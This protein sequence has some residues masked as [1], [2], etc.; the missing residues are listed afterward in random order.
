MFGLHAQETKLQKGVGKGIRQGSDCRHLKPSCCFATCSY[1]P[2]TSPSQA[3]INY[4][5]L[6]ALFYKWKESCFHRIM[7]TLKKVRESLKTLACSSGLQKLCNISPKLFLMIASVLLFSIHQIDN[8]FI[9][10][11]E[12]I[13]YSCSWALHSLWTGSI[14]EYRAKKISE[15]SWVKKIRKA[16]CPLLADFF[17][18]LYPTT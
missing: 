8:V 16:N 12:L 13:S 1:D 14:V 11:K 2:N 18:T 7:V 10:W 3:I 4:F 6:L 5:I 9:S 15:Q 17:F